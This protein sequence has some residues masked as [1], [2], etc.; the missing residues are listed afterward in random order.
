MRFRPIPALV[1]VLLLAGC[2][3]ASPTPAPSGPASATP[4][5]APTAAP[6]PT[7]G[8]DALPAPEGSATAQVLLH[9]GDGAY[10]SYRG[11]GRIDGLG[12]TCTFVLLDTVADEAA[13]HAPAY[14]LTNGHC[15]GLNDA[16]T[17]LVDQPAPDG[18]ATFDFFI[19]TPTRTTVTTRRIAWASMKSVDLAI[20]ELN[21]TLDQ[22]IASGH[23]P[24][25]IGERPVAGTRLVVVGAPIGVPVQDIP[26]ADRYLR[27]GTCA[28]GATDLVVNERQWLWRGMTANTCP[29]ILPGNSGSPVLDR[30]AGT[31]VGLVNTTTHGAGP[32]AV[33]CWLGNPCV[34]GEHGEASIADTNYAV[35]LD[36][37]AACFSGFGDFALGSACG[38]DPGTGVA[39]SGAPLA[40]N[41]SAADPLT[42]QPAHTTWGTT[43]SAGDGA[44]SYYRYKI[45]P[46]ATTVC[47]SPDDYGDPVSIADEPTIND[48]LPTTEQRLLLCVVGGASATPDASWQTAANATI[49]VAYIDTTAP[50]ARVQFS[51]DGSLATG[52]RIEPV[53]DPPTYSLFMIKGGPAATTDCGTTEGYVPYRRFATM[54]EPSQAPYRFCAMGFDDADNVGPVGET[55]LQ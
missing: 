26:E 34:P 49:A 12:S 17:V 46:L 18:K 55:V 44:Q 35:P 47:A 52:W 53:F 36:G 40:V 51:V 6:T 16:N 1:A 9:N 15:V 30:A 5:S 2:A 14:V 20:V 8:P 22:L 7:L 37:V 23:R 28:A 4:T 54:V 29:Q 24:W 32:D 43:V 39:I 48:P 33:T 25:P 19:D 38:L 11:I 41:P 31:L 42:G 10:D 50:T 13:D 21:T 27:A 45:G 3:P